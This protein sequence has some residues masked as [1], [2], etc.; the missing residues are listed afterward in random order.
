MK[1]IAWVI[2]STKPLGS[3][4]VNYL[5]ASNFQ[6]TGFSRT[7]P[8]SKIDHYQHRIIDLQA[9]DEFEKLCKHELENGAPNV[10]IF[11]QR[12]RA[13]QSEGAAAIEKGFR[14]EVLA[15]YFLYKLLKTIGS[16]VKTNFIFFTSGASKDIHLDID[17]PYHLYKSS[18][19]MLSKYIAVKGVVSGIRSNSVVLGEFLKYPL[20]SYGDHEVDK[21]RKLSTYATN[22]SICSIQDIENVVGFLIA[23]SSGYING[24]E[25]FLDGGFSSISVESLIRNSN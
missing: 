18:A 6:V 14:V 2:G 22:Q 5:V 17:F 25:I 12:Y 3:A 21:Y 1:K 9:I 7:P 24:Q 15:P 4:L 16:E 20:E 23:D 11:C 19:L 10:I 13:G 8:V